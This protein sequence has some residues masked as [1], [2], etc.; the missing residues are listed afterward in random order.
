MNTVREAAYRVD[1]ALWMQDVLGITPHDWQKTFPA[2]L[3]AVHHPCCPDRASGWQNHR[4]R[5]WEWPI[6][7]YS[8]RARCR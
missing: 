5:R 1:P 7:Q 6:R 8:C 4:R 2:S 3:R